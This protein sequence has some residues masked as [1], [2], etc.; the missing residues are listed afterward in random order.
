VPAGSFTP[1]DWRTRSRLHIFQRMLHAKIATVAFSVCFLLGAHAAND[2]VSARPKAQSA[3]RPSVSAVQTCNGTPIIMQGLPCRSGPARSTPSERADLPP[4]IPRGSSGAI[5]PVP[6]PTAPSLSLQRP[7]VTPYVPPPINSFSDRVTQCNQ[8][9][10][11]NAGVGNNPVGR[12][13][14]VRS[15]A[16]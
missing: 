5:P 4:R 11:F 15:C 3:A 14:Y 2:A 9:F 12:D 7:V 1:V 8:S 6:A 10:T 16:N 13:A